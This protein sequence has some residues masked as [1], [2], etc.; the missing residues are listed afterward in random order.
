MIGTASRRRPT[1][2]IAKPPMMTS[3]ATIRF[4]PSRSSRFASGL[5]R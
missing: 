3:A 5:S 2:T 1:K 4:N